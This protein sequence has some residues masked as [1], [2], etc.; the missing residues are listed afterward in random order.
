MERV[1]VPSDF[2]GNRQTKVMF[3]NSK[4]S[5]RRERTHLFLWIPGFLPQNTTQNFPPILWFA[6]ELG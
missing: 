3:R 4:L 2:K 6:R 5:R 1:A